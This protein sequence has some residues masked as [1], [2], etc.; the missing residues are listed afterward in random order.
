MLKNVLVRLDIQSTLNLISSSL[1]YVSDN[2][3]INEEFYN[4]H[5]PNKLK[6][7]IESADF[8]PLKPIN[9]NK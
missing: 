7:A 2:W 1:V 6:K 3:L 5:M 9:I 4:K 8:L